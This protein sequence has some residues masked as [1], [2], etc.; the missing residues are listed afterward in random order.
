MLVYVSLADQKSGKFL[1]GTVA[2]VNS[3]DQAAHVAI[4]RL[5]RQTGFRGMASVLCS[6]ITDDSHV[7]PALLVD[8]ILSRQELEA[9]GPL[10]KIDVC[11]KCAEGARPL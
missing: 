6:A 9:M 10:E 2:S 5:R 7:H 1:G 11:D 4:A 8:R 3:A